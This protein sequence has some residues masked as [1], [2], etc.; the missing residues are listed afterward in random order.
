M[1]RFIVHDDSGR[2]LRTGNC[3]PADV[4]FQA[5][6]PGETARVGAA[7][8]LVHYIAD[9]QVAVRPEIGVP[10]TLSLTVGELHAFS[11]PPGTDVTIDG[12][13][14]GTTDGTLELDFIT[15]GEFFVVLE[16]PFPYRPVELRV[17][18]T[19]PV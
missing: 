19:T 13:H 2:I 16:P 11:V 17:S 10:A 3:P 8:D 4:M 18:V 14:L 15:D 5:H 6:N 12:E 9:D 1:A 7:N